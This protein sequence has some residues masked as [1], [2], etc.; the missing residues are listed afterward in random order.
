MTQTQREKTAAAE[1][2]NSSIGKLDQEELRSRNAN[3]ITPI[4]CVHLLFV[5][6][7]APCTVV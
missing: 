3:L 1:T 2:F 5:P 4:T 6:S 7:P